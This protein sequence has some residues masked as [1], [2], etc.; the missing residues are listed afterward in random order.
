MKIENTL[1]VTNRNSWRDWLREH[2]E[3]ENEVWLIFYKKHTGRPRIDYVDAV[4]EA[5]CFGWIDSIVQ[6]MDDE[7]YAQKFT[8][9]RSN[10]KW[11][12]LNI[13][14]VK[15]LIK[16]GKMTPAG[17]EKFEIALKESGESPTL[18]MSELS[19]SDDLLNKLKDNPIA[20]ENF[21]KLP[22]SH[23]RNY[24]G[25]IMSAKREDTRRRRL[26]EA[27]ALLSQNKKLGLK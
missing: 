23:R 18:P 16:E 20:W 11:S 26:S 12:E 3:S 24:T 8:P 6:K 27:I 22:P 9:R 19:L 5:L 14:R 4:E 17:L 13:G 25:W 2:H 15:R 21:K 10:S 7:R 1:Y